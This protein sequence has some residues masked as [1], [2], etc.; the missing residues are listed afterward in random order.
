MRFIELISPVAKVVRF[1][2]VYQQHEDL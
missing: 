2:V 1:F